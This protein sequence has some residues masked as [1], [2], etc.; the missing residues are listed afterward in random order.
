M[1]LNRN[2]YIQSAQ[3][4]L[5]ALPEWKY[6]LVLLGSV[7]FFH[8]LIGF[9]GLEMTDEGWNLTG[10]QQIFAHPDSVESLFGVYNTLLVGGLWHMFFGSFGMIGF[11]IL[12]AIVLTGIAA[13]VYAICKNKVNRWIVYFSLIAVMAGRTFLMV[14]QYNYLSALV[15]LLV[16]I[17]IQKAIEKDSLPLMGVAGV[18]TGIGVFF[19]LPNL[20]F[21]G[22][23]L[24]LIL[25]YAYNNSI[26]RT[27][28]FLG[29]A[30]LGFVVGVGLNIALLCALGHQEPMRNLLKIMYELSTAEDSSHSLPHLLNMYFNQYREIFCLMGQMIL[31]AIAL[32][33]TK[34]YETVRW[35][36][37]TIYV[38]VVLASFAYLVVWYKINYTLGYLFVFGSFAFCY[39]IY[40][41]FCLRRELFDKDLAYLVAFSALM[42]ILMPLGSDIGIHNVGAFCLYLPVPVALG[43]LDNYFAVV[44]PEIQKSFRVYALILG[45][46]F[47]AASCASMM[48]NG[49][50]DK[51][52]RL[53][54]TE[55]LA[56]SA[57][58]STFTSIDKVE[59]LDAVLKAVQPILTSE[60]ELLSYPSAPILN[61]LTNTKPYLNGPWIGVLNYSVYVYEFYKA[62]E[63]K[64]LPVIVLI[65]SPVVEWYKPNPEWKNVMDC[66]DWH[67]AIED[68]N[69]LLASF[70]NRHSYEVYYDDAFFQVQIPHEP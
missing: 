20:C 37:I 52:S 5:T 17:C 43:V 26:Q 58:P 25:H 21:A 31:I 15:M 8:V 42:L 69:A 65:K 6:W 4:F 23:I 18:I 9:Q 33:W 40:F 36:K 16:I 22:L 61:Y 13:V 62:E 48:H 64:E 1:N 56:Y 19:R 24:V 2:R 7:F 34:K 14:L 55:Q 12:A 46:C 50:R 35:Q 49:Y 44:K 29:V 66:G 53:K 63:T 57:V 3:H 41:L 59:K 51:G 32:Y 47:I 27:F 45:L 28:S 38:L 54:M 68:K 60:T 70:M 30:V 39:F 11:R 67:P 10:Y